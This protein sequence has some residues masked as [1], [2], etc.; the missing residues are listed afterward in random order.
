MSPR[1]SCGWKRS[2][3]GILKRRFRIATL[4]TDRLFQSA[5]G[6]Y[7]AV[8]AVIDKAGKQFIIRR[9]SVSEPPN[10]Y[11]RNGSTEVALTSF[12]DPAPQIR[13]IQRQLITYK[14]ADG[15]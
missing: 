1:P 7:E 6:K 5:A 13:K 9:E 12:K 14:R 4:K 8:E 15:V 3:A 2:T 10:Y 11:L